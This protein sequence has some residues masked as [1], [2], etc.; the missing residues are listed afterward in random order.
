[1]TAG[2]LPRRRWA[3]RL[4]A[5]ALLALLT[6][7]GCRH[8]T[9]QLAA[10]TAERTPASADQLEELL[11]TAVP[12]GLPRMPDDRLQPPAGEK[13]LSDVASYAGD[14]SR[15]Q[16]VLQRYGYR[17]G[18]ERFWGRGAAE[19]SVF[20]DQFS[21][22]PGARAFAADLVRNDAAHYRA[23]PQAGTGGLPAGCRMLTVAQP[24]SDTGLDGPAAFAWCST[25]VFTVAVTAVSDTSA[26]ART[27]VSAVVRAQ[28]ERLG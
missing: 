27:E 28:L 7:A 8:G 11:V 13:S 22:A 25:G 20:V 14:P 9:Q 10:A 24:E 6:L 15:E 21:D 19:T 18:W 16:R 23:T 2:R 1:V 17:F 26:H 12:S 5:P 3:A 4:A